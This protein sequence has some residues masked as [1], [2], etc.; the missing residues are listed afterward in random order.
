M[1]VLFIQDTFTFN[2][3]KND[4]IINIVLQPAL[5]VHYNLNGFSMI[6]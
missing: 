1:V 3:N 5:K 2:G 6:Q 4:S